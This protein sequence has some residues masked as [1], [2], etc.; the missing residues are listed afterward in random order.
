LSRDI[1]E[2]HVHNVAPDQ[3]RY[4]KRVI[5]KSSSNYCA[6]VFGSKRQIAL[7]NT[8]ITCRMVALGS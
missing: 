3:Q 1:V 6:K 7:E 2:T 4:R 8:L 5:A